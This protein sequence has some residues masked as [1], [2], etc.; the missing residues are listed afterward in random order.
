MN[1]S[2]LI[3]ISMNSILGWIN[4]NCLFKKRKKCYQ[5]SQDFGPGLKTMLLPISSFCAL[6][7]ILT[8][9]KR[10]AQCLKHML[11]LILKGHVS[12]HVRHISLKF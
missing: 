12:D 3:M 8:L 1:I 11:E 4:N 2:S 6:S 5:E 9:H 10:S 7:L